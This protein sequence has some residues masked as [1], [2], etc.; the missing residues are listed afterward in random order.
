MIIII[1]A[2]F[3]GGLGYLYWRANY[4]SEPLSESAQQTIYKEYPG[5]TIKSFNYSPEN[6]FSFD[7]PSNE[8][9][10][11]L[12][13]KDTNPKLQFTLHYPW[14]K[15][16]DFYGAS[17]LFLIYSSS[18]HWFNFSDKAKSGLEKIILEKPYLDSLDN[19]SISQINYMSAK[20]GIPVTVNDEPLD[21]S[22]GRN[23]NNYY[24]FNTNS[25][26][27][28]YNDVYYLDNDQW[29]FYERVNYSR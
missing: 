16:R 9:W 17:Y 21:T 20:S 12:L 6:P 27:I 29:V 14:V 3:V 8:S 13:S 24:I 15:D 4:Y 10:D 11:V 22:D 28:K 23:A 7:S 25:M 26:T 5:F 2:L 19:L 18:Y 1:F